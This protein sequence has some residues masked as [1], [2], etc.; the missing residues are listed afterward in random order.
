MCGQWSARKLNEAPADAERTEIDPKEPETLDESA[1]LSLGPG[2]VPR[3]EQHPPSPFRRGITG[4]QMWL[5]VV[6]GFHHPRARH[7]PGEDL[8]RQ[9]SV[10][11][12]GLE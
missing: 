12:C 2:V 9:M 10:K 11:L 7:E 3:V 8:A 4:E 1:D 5:K 6:E